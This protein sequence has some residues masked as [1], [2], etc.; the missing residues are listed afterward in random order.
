MIG[1]KILIFLDKKLQN[2]PYLNVN[3]WIF[4]CLDVETRK[5]HY[6]IMKAGS[7]IY[8]LTMIK[9]KMHSGNEAKSI[10]SVNKNNIN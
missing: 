3:F 2:Y 7:K 8:Y 6:L 5:F 4:K 1:G 9:L 10:T